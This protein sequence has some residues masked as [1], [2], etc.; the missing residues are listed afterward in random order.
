MRFVALIPIGPGE[1]E[2][3]R[4]SDLLASLFHFEAPEESGVLLVNDGNSRSQLQELISPYPLVQS[5]ILDNPR[6]GVGDAWSD[7]LAVGIFAGL[8]YLA[9]H[10]SGAQFV[11]KLDTDS[12]VISPFADKIERFFLNQPTIGM[13]GSHL[14]EPGGAPTNSIAV[15][16]PRIKKL[17]RYFTIWNTPTGWQVQ[18]G[19]WGR[20][21]RIRKL[22]AQ[23]SDRGYTFGES[24]IGGGYALSAATVQKIHHARLL[25]DP[26]LFLHRPITEDVI[27][28]LLAHAVGMRLAD[29]NDESQPFG[30]LWRGLCAS[31][32][33]LLS[34]GYSIIHSVKDSPDHSESDTRAF[35]AKRRA[36]LN[37]PHPRQ[38]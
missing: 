22:I 34:R 23:A 17:L 26:K 1:T 6:E 10:L 16:T 30:V 31:P 13:V 37:P 12:L 25:D 14:R 7:G 27:V 29:F 38:S 15:W 19:L 35:F 18:F 8:H 11:L 32:T 33:K 3:E 4:L 9:E 28:S 36:A 2:R 21:H 20:D 24:C 5:A